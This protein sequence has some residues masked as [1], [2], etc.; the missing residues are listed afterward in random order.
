VAGLWPNNPSLRH[1]RVN[2]PLPVDDGTDIFG[3]GFM[4]PGESL[5]SM[6]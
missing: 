2:E 5:F 4:T 6:V 3:T 1:V